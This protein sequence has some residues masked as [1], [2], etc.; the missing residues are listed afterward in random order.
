MTSVKKRA[1][2]ALL[3]TTLAAACGMAGGYMLGG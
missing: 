3:A 1:L 2:A